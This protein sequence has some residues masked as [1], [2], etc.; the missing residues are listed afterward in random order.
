MST[1]LM[2]NKKFISPYKIDDKYKMC[3]AKVYETLPYRNCLDEI[4]EVS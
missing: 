4:G 3:K 2:W 1:E